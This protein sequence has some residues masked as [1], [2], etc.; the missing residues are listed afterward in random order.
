MLKLKIMSVKDPLYPKQP[1]IIRKPYKTDPLNR[2]SAQI[3]FV[4]P[5]NG[6]KNIS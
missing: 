4:G 1:Q 2:Y 6:S 3:L 5:Q